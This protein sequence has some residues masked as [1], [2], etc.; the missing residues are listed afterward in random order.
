MQ[1]QKNQPKKEEE[2]K[3]LLKINVFAVY[4]EKF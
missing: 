3:L 2:N 4:Y 1:W